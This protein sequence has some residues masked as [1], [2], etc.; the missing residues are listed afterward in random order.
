MAARSSVIRVSV[1]G[2]VKDLQNAFKTTA[3]GAEKWA[4][5]MEKAGKRLTLGLTAPIVA[6][7]T[8]ATKAAAEEAQE[9]AK[10][11]DVIRRQVPGATQEMIDANEEW[12]TNLQNSTGIA[13]GELR[14]L[15]QKFI[16]AGASIEDAQE[17]ATASID[18]AIATGKDYKSISDAMVKGMNGQ[19]A[20]FSKLGLE[21]KNADG[22]MKSLDEILQDLAVHHGAAAAAADTDAGRAAIAQAKMADLAETVGSFLLPIMAQLSDWLSKVA[23]WFNNLDPSGQKMI[24]MLG[25]VVAAVGPVLLIASKLVTAFGVVGKAFKALSLLMS[26]NPWVLLIAATVALVMLIINNWDKI[27]A[28]L[29]KVWEAIKAAAK[30]TWDWIKSAISAAVQFVTNLF[31]NWTLPGLIIKHWDKIRDGVKALIDF[32]KRAWDGVI[33]W[34]TSLPGRIGSAVSGMW[35]GIKTAFKS[36]INW[37]IDKWNG[38]S[39]KIGPVSFPSWVPG[40]GGKSIAL[41]LNTPNIPRL[42]SGGVFQAPGGAREGLALLESGE[43][44]LPRGAS[45]GTQTIVN[46]TVHAG[47]GTDPYAIGRGIVEVLQR[48]EKVNGAI[49]ISVRAG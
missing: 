9:M 14:A 23:D 17:M 21:T 8:L 46:V 43:R 16:A 34:F 38:L 49:P 45:S 2:D 32:I 42:H 11:A 1:F 27:S 3:T 19:T 36:A 18:T 13:D 41:T 28:F 15:S 20:G 4:G 29:T 22:T 47:L 6:G 10:L 5:G 48:Y 44:V 33:S 30:A 40:I 35:D 37:V 25:G 39:L 12:I 31:L 7:A 26:A 24:V